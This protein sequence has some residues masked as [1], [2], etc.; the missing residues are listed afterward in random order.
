MPLTI[1][2]PTGNIIAPTL[3]DGPRPITYPAGI[4]YLATTT[5]TH[6]VIHVAIAITQT[7][8]NALT[9]ADATLI[10]RGTAITYAGAIS[11]IPC[12]VTSTFYNAIATAIT[13]FVND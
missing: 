12:T 3:I 9:P 7:Q 4:Q 8:R 10:D 13:A 11:D 1:T 6:A 5:L 2:F